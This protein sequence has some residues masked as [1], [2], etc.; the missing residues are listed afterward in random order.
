LLFQ[1]LRRLGD[2]KGHGFGNGGDIVGDEV[3]G[4]G[5]GGQGQ[6]RGEGIKA[7]ARQ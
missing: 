3:H 5:E 7:L 1:R 2:S 4:G 6:K